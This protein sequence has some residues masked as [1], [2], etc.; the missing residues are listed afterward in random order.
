MILFFNYKIF[1]I[2]NPKNDVADTNLTDANTTLRSE[3]FVPVL[4][5]AVETGHMGLLTT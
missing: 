3:M 5:N 4:S 1:Q 2:H